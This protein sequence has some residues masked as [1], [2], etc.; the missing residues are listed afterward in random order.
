MYRKLAE[1]VC[2]L[3]D[4]RLN[5]GGSPLTAEESA[6]H[7]LA[8]R[9]LDRFPVVCLSRDDL[10]DAGIDTSCLSDDDLC[11]MAHRLGDHYREDSF[12]Q[13]LSSVA[14]HEGLH[15]RFLPERIRDEWTWCCTDT[16]TPRYA[17]V[18]IRYKGTDT[19][20]TVHISIGHLPDGYCPGIPGLVFFH[21]V[22]DIDSLCRLCDTTG[23]YGFYVTDFIEFE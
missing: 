6:V 10:K 5:M 11:A 13:S 16:F 19:T 15:H 23:R 21:H 17:K 4:G 20:E 12:H 18:T 8:T 3:F 14:L 2:R 1:S 22:E 9:C 7:N